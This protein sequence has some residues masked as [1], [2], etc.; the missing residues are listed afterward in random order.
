MKDGYAIAR[1]IVDQ[2]PVDGRFPSVR[3]GQRHELPR[4]EKRQAQFFGSNGTDGGGT[5]SIH[6]QNVKMPDK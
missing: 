2:D 3:H 4:I 5:F 1:W 6:T